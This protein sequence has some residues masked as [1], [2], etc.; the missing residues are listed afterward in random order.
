VGFQFVDRI[1]EVE[2]GRSARGLLRVG[3]GSI[4]PSLVAEAIGQLAAWAAM[5]KVDFATRPVAALA[6]EVEALGVPAPGAV[7]DLAVEIESLDDGAVAYGGSASVDGRPVVRLAR[8]LGPMLP[9]A[10]LDDAGSLA[11]RFAAL[12]VGEAPPAERPGADA[13][14]PSLCG[15]ARDGGRRVAARLEVPRFASF[16]DDHFP[17]RPVLPGTLL[18]D[19]VIGLAAELALEVG[20]PAGKAPA[21]RRHVRGVK[22]RAFVAP[23]DALDLAA[24]IRSANDRAIEIDLSA[25][26]A[27][28]RLLDARA[29]L[30]LEERA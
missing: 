26:R 2:A 20:A 13:L 6:G 4:S 17:R 29:I 24:E 28:K 25:R 23:G 7:V 30:P 15:L 19:A 14:R 21:E 9:T 22:L 1:L 12:C 5:A 18:L 3:P 11:E 10:E 8:C 27:G 16:F